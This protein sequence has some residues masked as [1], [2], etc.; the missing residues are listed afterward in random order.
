MDT[1]LSQEQLAAILRATGQLPP[2][3]P[4]APS[5]QLPRLPA[6]GPAASSPRLSQWSSLVDNHGN[7]TPQAYVDLIVKTEDARL[8]HVRIVLVV[9][10]HD[11]G[12]I[13]HA[14]RRSERSATFCTLQEPQITTDDPERRH[15]AM[16]CKHAARV[17]SQRSGC[18]LNNVG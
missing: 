7:C 18:P 11:L 3:S 16:H 6:A 9:D 5:P 15:A 2:V 8:G 1:M 4:S 14:P 17:I 10:G 12:L 13:N